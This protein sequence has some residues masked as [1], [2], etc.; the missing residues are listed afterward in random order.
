M[1]VLSPDPR[2]ISSSWKCQRVDGEHRSL[3]RR[4]SDDEIIKALRELRR[5]QPTMERKALQRS[6][7]GQRA[8]E[9]FG[10]L[11]DALLA[12]RIR[13]W[14][15]RVRRPVASLRQ[16]IAALRA[17]RAAG[18]L[19]TV[20]AVAKADPRLRLAV[21][22]YFPAFADALAAAGI[23]SAARRRWS[24]A[25]VIAELRKRSARQRPMNSLAVEKDDVRLFKAA[26][27]RFGAWGKVL[28]AAGVAPS[29]GRV[30]LKG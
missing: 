1:R 25:E 18:K 7:V 19:M 29:G 16:T 30:H 20:A 13:G 17:R 6:A 11:D 2:G 21:R 15:R 28:A 5:E 8:E 9:H 24:A 3:L 4:W 27:R 22:R 14:P 23:A 26:K 10:G 12:A